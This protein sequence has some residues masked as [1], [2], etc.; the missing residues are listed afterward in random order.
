MGAESTVEAVLDVVGLIPRGRVLTY[1]DIALLVGTSPRRVGTI[2]AQVGSEVTWWRVTNARGALPG[3]LA[4][5]AARRW[6]DEAIPTTTD[7]TRCLVQ[8][9]RADLAAIAEALDEGAHRPS[10]QVPG[11]GTAQ[12]GI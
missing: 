9:C 4:G 6:A 3:H 7:G 11:S 5:R 1:G 2:M 8:S 12:S 10:P